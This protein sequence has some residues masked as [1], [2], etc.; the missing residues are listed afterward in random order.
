MGA[1]KFSIITVSKGRLDHLKQS[2]PRMLGQG[3]AEVIVV[4]YSC[5][6]GTGDYVEEHFPEARVVKV[7]GE[8]YFSNWKA[9][10][11]GAAAATGDVLVFCD[12]DTILAKDA[13]ARIDEKLPQQSYGFF[14]PYASR[15][16][17]KQG[18]RLA[19][20]QLRGFHVIPAPAFRTAQGYDELFEGYAA[21][22]DTDLED[23]L[24]YIGFPQTVLDP[25]IVEE[26]IQHGNEERLEH[27]REPIQL[28]YGAG[29]IYRTAKYALVKI[30]RVAEIPLETRQAL[31]KSARAAAETLLKEDS[32]ALSIT[33]NKDPI[34]MPRQLGFESGTLQLSIRVEVAGKKPVDKAPD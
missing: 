33:A 23:R 6:E 26:V 3:A 28:S 34:G 29:L 12:A 22:A 5:P 21:G 17:N 32:I 1:R 8:A 2:L 25:S 20:N 18:L 30:R 16:F 4:D 7:E 15:G 14:K 11:A 31:Y 24:I 19:R 9:R 27:H 10:N 13:L